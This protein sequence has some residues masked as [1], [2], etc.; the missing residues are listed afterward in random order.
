MVARRP[1]IGVPPGP[2]ARGLDF[3]GFDHHPLAAQELA[4]A[5]R[6]SLCSSVPKTFSPQ[7]SLARSAGHLAMPR[8]RIAVSARARGT[9]VP[10]GTAFPPPRPPP[11]YRRPVEGDLPCR[12]GVTPRRRANVEQS[13]TARLPLLTR[14]HPISSAIGS[15][16]CGSQSG[17]AMRRLSPFQEETG[18]RRDALRPHHP[19]HES[20]SFVHVWP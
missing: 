12:F 7:A 3:L 11:G 6:A 9:R 2:C 17:V 16:R 20:A 8:S 15:V 5:R 10:K 1:A 4:R 18:S 13:P 19:S 14:L